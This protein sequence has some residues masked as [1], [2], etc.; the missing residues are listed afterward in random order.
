MM[1]WAQLLLMMFREPARAMS[2]VRDR[3]PLMHAALFAWLAESIYELVTGPYLGSASVSRFPL[4]LF[5]AL[6]NS[7]QSL[8][9]IA[10][11]FAPVMIIVSNLF[12]RRASAGLIVQQ[13]YAATASVIFCAWAAANLAAIPVAL[14]AKISG[15]QALVIEASLQQPTQ[16]WLQNVSEADRRQL[17]A[18]GLSNLIVLPFFVL[19]TIVAV[20]ELFHRSWPRAA[21]VATTGL[22]AGV[23]VMSLIAVLL[24]AVPFLGGLLASP[25]VL[26]LLFFLLRS[27]F[28]D[29]TRAH[30]ARASFK[31]N[32]EAATL[33]PADASAHYNLG[34]LHLKR[35]ELDEARKRFERAVE[36]DPDEVDAHFQLGRIS[37]TQNRYADAIKHYEQ[38][39][40]RDPAHAQHEIWR[41][42]GATY[43]A[44]GQYEDAREALGRFLEHRG[45][46]PEGLYLMGRALA[47]LGQKTEAAERLRACI[48]AVQSAPAYNY[49][50]E[51][52]WLNEAQQFL[53]SLA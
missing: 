30:R 25:F 37:R 22:V 44:A 48:E 23:L 5:A 1:K 2:E 17:L 28:G 21:V 26:L 52:R 33:N 32:L 16:V 45:S 53:R 46:D 50:T 31:Q 9:L 47:G 43:I 6:W 15:L 18:E 4:A 8:L 10:L 38:V 7:A 40:T 42:I 14:L 12:D 11:I 41:E 29:V 13:E 27:Y 34:L 3:A 49:R 51:K 20:R 39:V 19:W 35:N 36:V 24:T